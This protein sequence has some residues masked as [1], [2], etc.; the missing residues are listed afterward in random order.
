MAT[1]GRLY[2]SFL[3]RI[4]RSAGGEQRIEVEQIQTGA[5]ARLNSLEDVERW[6][7]AQ[8]AAAAAERR[9]GE[10]ATPDAYDTRSEGA[11]P[12]DGAAQA[13]RDQ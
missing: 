12:D 7:E 9:E 6:I 13:S 1:R 2:R 8:Q 4:W 11:R 10:T 3:V 5:R